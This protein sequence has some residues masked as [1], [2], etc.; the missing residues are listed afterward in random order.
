[1][2]DKK[3]YWADGGFYHSD[4]HAIIPAGAI[5]LTIEQWEALLADQSAGKQII[6]R[7]GEIIA[8]DPT[9][10]L[11]DEA[12]AAQIAAVV[13]SERDALLRATDYLMMPD[14]PLDESF[15]TDV[16]TYRQALRDI[17]TQ[18]GFPFDIE[19]PEKPI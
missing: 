11:T 7:D 6:E 9:E 12:K 17:T 2:N 19:W 13:R 5:E 8:V 16:R 10:L 18:E 1:M 15:K 3:I 14:Y 4:I